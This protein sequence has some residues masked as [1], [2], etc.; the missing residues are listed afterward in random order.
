[1]RLITQIVIALIVSGYEKPK[2]TRINLILW[3]LL[4]IV[5]LVF[6]SS[7]LLEFYIF[8]EASLFPI[9]SLI[10]LWGY[11]PERFKARLILLFYTSIAS[12]PLL[13]LTLRTPFSHFYLSTSLIKASLSSHLLLYFQLFFL[14]AVL[15][16]IPIF[17][18]HQW[19]PK[20]HVEAPVEGSMVL[21][22]VLLKLGGFG[23]YRLLPV[24]GRVSPLAWAIGSLSLIGSSLIRLV[25]LYQ[26]DMKILIAYSSVAH[27]RLVIA[28]LLLAS[29]WGIRA[30][31]TVIVA[32]GAS[33]SLLFALAHLLYKSSSSRS[34][35][36]NKGVLLTAPVLSLS[37]FLACCTNMAAPLSLNLIGELLA[38]VSLTKRSAYCLVPFGVIIFLAAGYSLGLYRLTQHGKSP[39]SSRRAAFLRKADLLIVILH[40]FFAFRTC[41]TI[42]LYI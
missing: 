9:F 28:P 40:L 15:V 14:A 10:L 11:Q 3:A 17:G 37:I 5:V 1:M 38:V 36:F 25:C 27:I 2:Y 32:H 21:A 24:R 34:I 41:V 30:G 20:A 39:L 18:P 22:A 33:S 23:L 19:L 4:L 16:K 7:T 8:F 29:S 26:F 12:L 42:A 35:L 31:L 13:L 6:A